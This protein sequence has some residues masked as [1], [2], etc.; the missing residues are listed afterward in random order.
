MKIEFQQID[1]ILEFIPL[2]STINAL[3]QFAAQAVFKK[4]QITPD[5]AGSFKPIV[6][7]ILKKNQTYFFNQLIPFYGNFKTYHS[8]LF[9]K[10]QKHETSTLDFCLVNQEAK[11]KEAAK[12]NQKALALFLRKLKSSPYLLLTDKKIED[13]L[14][15]EH[16]NAL[17]SFKKKEPF[18]FDPNTI[19][20]ISF[21]K[22]LY[23]KKPEWMKEMEKRQLLYLFL[24]NT[25]YFVRKQKA[26][27]KKEF[28]QKTQ[29][30]VQRPISYRREPCFDLAGCIRKVALIALFFYV[31][32]LPLEA[33]E[34]SIKTNPILLLP[35]PYPQTKTHTFQNYIEPA[36]EEEVVANYGEATSLLSAIF[37][38]FFVAGY[39]H[40]RA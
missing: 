18:T 30:L 5:N 36:L 27:L 21:R 26:P 34:Q 13:E 14:S 1:Q 38:S 15:K 10:E 20:A 6:D 4:L 37:G 33:A 23:S 40:L 3:V 25:S 2:V 35:T 24:E 28:Q 17:N 31:A 9:K 29:L 7:I 8:L 12:L 39:A 19:Q 32:Q 11:K 16:V 22:M